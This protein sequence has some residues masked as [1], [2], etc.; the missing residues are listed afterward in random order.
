M[1]GFP[2]IR[3]L[4]LGFPIIRIIVYLGL[5]GGPPILGNCHILTLHH[6]GTI[7][8]G[9]GP[10]LAGAPGRGKDYMSYSLN[11]LNGVI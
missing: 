3:G 2:K 10:F 5:Y 7:F 11:S 8:N 4:F 1:W 6:L 9:S